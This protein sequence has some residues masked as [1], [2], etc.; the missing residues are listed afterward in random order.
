VKNRVRPPKPAGPAPIQAS[1]AVRGLPDAESTIGQQTGNR[2]ALNLEATL[3]EL[4]GMGTTLANKRKMAQSFAEAE[5][6]R[7]SDLI[8]GT[9]GDT[10]SSVGLG[11]QEAYE[12][13]RAA[14]NAASNRIWDKAAQQYA[15]EPVI[16]DEIIKVVDE[17]ESQ[18]RKRGP[19]PGPLANEFKTLRKG[20]LDDVPGKDGKLVTKRVKFE[21]FGDLWENMKGVR[22]ILRK[23]K[24]EGDVTVGAFKKLE[25]TIDSELTRVANDAGGETWQVAH[26]VEEQFRRTFDRSFL[27]EM[28]KSNDPSKITDMLTKAPAEE[29]ASM[30]NILGREAWDRARGQVIRDSINKATR[31]ALLEGSDQSVSAAAMRTRL[32]RMQPE[33]R[34]A[35]WSPAEQKSIDEVFKLLDQADPGGSNLSPFIER[36]VAMK[37]V[38]GAA[39][40]AGVGGA[41]TVGLPTT[42]AVGAG[43]GGSMRVTA[44]ILARPALVRGLG[45]GLRMLRREGADLL[46]PAT[47][48]GVAKRHIIR[49]VSEARQRSEEEAKLQSIPDTPL[50][51]GLPQ[52]WQS[53]ASGA[54]SPAQ[55]ADD[56]S[57][58]FP[59]IR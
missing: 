36:V 52:D 4:P 12:T 13:S 18:F 21:T 53:H 57:S 10:A 20:F 32:Q 58:R 31:G 40:M 23:A 7:V 25:D 46:N 33:L 48:S 27:K 28:V 9:T 29:I 30:K 43:L 6:R 14:R 44:E 56:L 42:L 11:V 39:A 3:E 35:L 1:P 8:S 51:P 38:Q 50:L 37:G 19:V 49:V 54:Q 24:R 34:D 2:L 45:E 59:G 55:P 17:L 15:G 22:D 47:W 5:A 26:S 16:M 41:S